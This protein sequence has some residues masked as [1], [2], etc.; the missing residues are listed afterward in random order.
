MLGGAMPAYGEYDEARAELEQAIAL[1]DAIGNK[2]QL[3]N[4]RRELGHV[5]HCV[6]DREE[7]W[8]VLEQALAMETELK[9]PTSRVLTV[10]VLARAALAEE[11]YER[12]TGL[13]TEVLAIARDGRGASLVLCRL[14]R[15]HLGA[16][17]EDEARAAAEEAL[18]GIEAVSIFDGPEIYYAAYLVLGRGDLLDEA[19]KRVEDR[20]RP[21]RNDTF[22]EHFL[23]RT[24]PNREIT[25][26]PPD[27]GPRGGSS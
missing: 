6:G 4:A 9:D 7:A 1:A 27:G 5:L 23:T 8:N 16:G 22:R 21:I 13:L 19:R 26:D 24:W 18:Q 15:A 3:I 10:G 14:A 11:D 17:R 2:A 20:A 25:R 12:A